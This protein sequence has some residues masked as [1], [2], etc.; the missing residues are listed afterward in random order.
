M[1]PRNEDVMSSPNNLNTHII[2]P[3]EEPYMAVQKTYGGCFLTR[4]TLP[5][6]I[7]INNSLLWNG[8][9]WG[10]EMGSKMLK[11]VN[12]YHLVK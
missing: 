12:R 11:Y 7:Q 10:P 4:Q 1:A 2:Y 9:F 6:L 5:Y 8:V 3:P